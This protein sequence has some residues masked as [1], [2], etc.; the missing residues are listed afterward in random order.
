MFGGLP[1]AP[2]QKHV[3][4]INWV[5]ASTWTPDPDLDLEK[6]Y[7]IGPSWGSWKT[8]RSCSTHNVVCHDMTRAKILVE[9]QFQT[10]CNLYVPHQHYGAL[11]RPGQ[12]Q[13]YHGDYQQSTVDIEDIVA[14]HLAAAN[15]DIVLM[16]GFDLRA[17]PDHDHASDRVQWRNQMGLLS[18]AVASAAAVQF[19]LVDH[20]TPLGKS[21][22]HLK[23]LTCDKLQNM[24]QLLN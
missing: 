8:W 20:P 1:V 7:K 5:F 24:L 3:M 16:T 6:L 23:N 9:R 2:T 11:G 22:D 13:L 4:R 17:Q 15:S 21:F 14:V 18:S 10:K 19:V 12:I